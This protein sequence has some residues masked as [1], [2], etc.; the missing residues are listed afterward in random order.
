[1]A[2]KVADR[3]SLPLSQNEGEVKVIKPTSSNSIGE[4]PLAVNN[5]SQSS[6]SIRLSNTKYQQSYSDSLPHPHPQMLN[7][8]F[9][10]RHREQHPQSL[11]RSMFQPPAETGSKT[12][13][14]LKQ[15]TTGD[16]CL[17]QRPKTPTRRAGV[18]VPIATVSPTSRSSFE[19]LLR[20]PT[21]GRPHRDLN[22]GQ[23]QM[24]A[25]FVCKPQPKVT[26]KLWQP[27][28]LTLPSSLLT[29]ANLSH[30]APPPAYKHFPLRS[31]PA[32][33]THHSHSQAVAEHGKLKASLSPSWQ[34]DSNDDDTCVALDLS[35]RSSEKDVTCNSSPCRPGDVTSHLSPMQ[36]E[37]AWNLADAAVPMNL[38]KNTTSLSV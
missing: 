30:S 18:S 12:G 28:S 8:S 33:H 17:K 32:F 5:L 20:T 27:P 1:M 29:A 10:A 25:E 22:Q 37:K 35:C 13:F 15:T 2:A 16:V 11:L 19:S 3:V 31:Q 21:A 9:S 6:S 23:G 34:R 4:R 7:S 36:A 26:G 38:S 24:D 14:L